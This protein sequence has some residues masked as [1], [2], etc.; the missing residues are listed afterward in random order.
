VDGE[1]EKVKVV[2]AEQLVEINH[3]DSMMVIL[4]MNK[5][6]EEGISPVT[7]PVTGADF[8][9]NLDNND[10]G[11]KNENLNKSSVES[12]YEEYERDQERKRE[13]AGDETKETPYENVTKIQ[14]ESSSSGSTLKNA[15]FHGKL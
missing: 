1:E 8:G 5:D 6:S 7:S 11:A 2:L 12:S 13:T 4:S 10:P 3:L 14:L 9:P 15:L